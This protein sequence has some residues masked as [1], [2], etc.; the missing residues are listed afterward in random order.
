M[1]PRAR[2]TGTLLLTYACA[3]VRNTYWTLPFF[4]LC[5]WISGGGPKFSSEMAENSPPDFSEN[6]RPKGGGLTARA[7]NRLE[8]PLPKR[9]FLT[10]PSTILLYY[11]A[12]A[13]AI[14]NDGIR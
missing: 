6:L 11:T 13:E 14:G 4:R 8:S 12:N 9:R 5:S 10:H 2:I 3:R 1:P 7:C